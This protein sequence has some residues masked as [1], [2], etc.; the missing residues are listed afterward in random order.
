MANTIILK[1]SATPGKVPTTGQLA[2]GEI[3]IN[4]YDGLIYI[5]KNDGTE[6]IAQIGGVTSVNGETGAVTIDTGDVAENGNL[7]FT[8]ARARGAISA[9]SGISYNSSTGAI[10][11]AQTLTTA[12]TP[13]FAG[14]T[15]TGSISSIAGDIIPSADITYDLGS[16]TRQ[17]KDIYVGPGSLYVNGQKVLQDDTGTITFSAD[18]DQNIR[19]K[20]LGNGILQLGSSTT[21]LQVDSTLQITSGKN[22]TDSSGIKVNFGDNIEMNGNKVIGLGAPSSA[23]DAATKT[24]VDTA[25]GNISTSSI[26]QGNS[27]V[28]VT[29]TGTGSVTVSVDG[30]T[31]LTVSSSG[32]VVAGNFTV[33]GTTTTIEANTINLADNII[34]LNSDATGAPTQNAGI[35]VERGDE[36]N[37]QLRWNEGSQKWTFTN[38]GAVYFPMAVGTDDLAEGTTN[39]YHTA[40]RARSALSVTSNTGISYNSSTGVFGLGSIPNSSLTNNSITINGTSVALGGT[41]ILDTDAINEGSTNQYYTNARSRGALSAGTGISYNSTT[42]AISTSAIPNA[43]LSNSSVTVGTTAIALGASSTTLG[44]LTSV[45]STSFTGA[46]TGN[47]DTATTAGKWTTARTI[48]L[49]GD[50][51][52]SV[53]FDGS[54][55]ATLTATVAANSV[56]LGT[57]TTGDYVGS[58]VAGTGITL[59]NNTGEG[60]TPTVTVDTSTIATRS[61]VDT[62][63]AGKDNT[64]EI[65][66]GSSNL[67]FTNARARGAVSFTAGSGAYNSTT[68]VFTIPTNTNQLTNGAN[69]A[70]TSYV[71]SAVQGKDNTDEI[72]EGSSNLYFTNARARGAVSAGTGISYNSTTGVITNTITQYTDALAR[73]AV[74]VTDSGGDG[75]L[76]YNSTTG[77][78][79]YTGPSASEVR[80][81]FSAGTGITIT[82]GAIATTITQYTDALATTAARA[83]HSVTGG[84]AAYNTTTGVITV[85]TTTAHITESGNLFYTDARAVSANTTAIATA[86]SEAISAAASDAT[87][88]ANAAQ[89]AAIAAV[90]NGAGAAFDT[91]KEIQDA[92]ATDAELA[93]AIAAITTVPNATKLATARTINGVSFDGTANVTVTTAGTGISVSGTTV[94]N[95]LSTSGGSIGG[96]I[97]VSGA[98][99]ATGEVTAYFSDLRLKTNI[100]PIADALDKVEAINGVTFDPNEAALALG[101]DARHQM[102]VI[103]QEVE[104]VAPE[105]VCDSAFAGYKTV[106]YDKLTALLIEAVKELSA[107]VK[108]LEAQLGNTKPT[109]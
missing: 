67:Y 34:T 9:G 37:V 98:I 104:A 16:P 48:T 21:T 22:I 25:I 24:Y 109:L 50:L 42:G 44:G 85:P 29:D 1:R 23:N 93:S 28:T 77:V 39:L 55:N 72:T 14:L 90:T 86:K 6:S 38:N 80:A 31:A 70:T 17:W 45:T 53:S 62:A 52:G 81:H 102:G 74:S 106:R 78:I 79:T 35:E 83:A 84:S 107:K 5:K 54:A 19:I 32:V 33:Q 101:I 61:Y 13:T 10:S 60:A 91:L 43:S 96:S 71:D 26:Q 30:S 18:A 20:T 95:T 66:E 97:A 56:A 82:N 65:T 75:S 89:A 76:S 40:A 105:L 11:T 88:K 68:G 8:N 12:G 7:Y 57:D 92:M 73:G 59:S 3:A 15:L 108:T 87:T 69:F 99:T 49:G 46:L 63:V 27:N 58:L 51:T 2:L 64:D 36:A 4:T 94:T 100:V 47:A 103:A 41:R